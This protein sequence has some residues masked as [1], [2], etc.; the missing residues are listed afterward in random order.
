MQAKVDEGGLRC[1]LHGAR[2]YQRTRELCRL[3]FSVSGIGARSSLRAFRLEHS[4]RA[5]LVASIPRRQGRDSSG[6][7]ASS[8]RMSPSAFDS[9]RPAAAGNS[10]RLGDE[11]VDGTHGHL[12]VNR[13]TV[14]AYS[15]RAW[16]EECL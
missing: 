6:R 12:R 15:M 5:W 16:A 2:V 1:A 7:H 8:P 10:P 14:N 4:W 13:R 3:K 11:L 9:G